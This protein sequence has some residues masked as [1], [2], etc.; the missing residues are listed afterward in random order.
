MKTPALVGIIGGV[1]GLIVGIGAAIFTLFLGGLGSMAGVSGSGKI[2]IAGILLFIFALIGLI[3]GAL[4]DS[5]PK[6]GGLLMLIGGL[7]G[8]LSGWGIIW[9]FPGI[10]LLIGGFLTLR[11]KRT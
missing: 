3:G 5:N 7:G 1:I 2:I 4:S 10:L 9:L 11:E 6:K 8:F